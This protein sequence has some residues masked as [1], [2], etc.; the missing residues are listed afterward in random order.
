MGWWFLYISWS[1]FLKIG[2]IL[3][4]FH[5]KGNVPVP[6]QSSKVLQDGLHIDVPQIFIIWILMLSW[7]WTLFGS[8]FWIAFDTILWEIKWRQT[9][10]SQILNIYRKCAIAVYQNA[11]IGSESEKVRVEESCFLFNPF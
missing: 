5:Y 4:L 6:K 2:T 3:P 1:P 9:I 7:P 11:L 10:V 8:S